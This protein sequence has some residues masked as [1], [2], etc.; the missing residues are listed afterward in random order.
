MGILPNRFPPGGIE[1]LAGQSHIFEGLIHRPLF[2]HPLLRDCKARTQ[3]RDHIMDAELVPK[4]VSIFHLF[5]D[6]EPVFLQKCTHEGPKSMCLFLHSTDAK[7]RHRWP[8]HSVLENPYIGDS[9][10]MGIEEEESTNGAV[11]SK[12]GHRDTATIESLTS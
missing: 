9:L 4:K 3:I 7:K 10:A 11:Y 5:R 6:H 2:G 1:I 12:T 8:R